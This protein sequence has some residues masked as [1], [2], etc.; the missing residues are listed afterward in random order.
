MKSRSLILSWIILALGSS[1]GIARTQI[2]PTSPNPYTQTVSR[3]VLA[4]G[5]PQQVPDRLLE[6]VRYTIPSGANLPIHYHPGM[7]IERVE[8]G[9]LTYTVVKGSAQIVRADGRKETLEE[10]QTTLLKVGDS[11]AEPEGMIHYGKNETAN[12]VILLGASIF[13][14]NQPKAILVKP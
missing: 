2:T 6:L 4:S 10:G 5:S 1:V 14:A 11:L 7:Q 8:F 9:I 12:P 13:A 3:E